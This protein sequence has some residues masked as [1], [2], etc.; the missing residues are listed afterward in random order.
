[1]KNYVLET[2]A[3]RSRCFSNGLANIL[4]LPKGVPS[5]V[6]KML[7]ETP[8]PLPRDHLEEHTRNGPPKHPWNHPGATKEH[9]RKTP[10]QHPRNTQGT[11]QEHPRNTPKA[12]QTQPISTLKTSLEHPRNTQRAPR[13]AQVHPRSTPGSPQGAAQKHSKSVPGASPE[14][15]VTPPRGTN[16]FSLLFNF[17]RTGSCNLTTQTGHFTHVLNHSFYT[18]VKSHAVGCHDTPPVGA[19]CWFYFRNT[20]F[21]NCHATSFYTST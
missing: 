15:G 8:P 9:P 16:V 3:P 21:V 13:N 2:L 5:T 6:S 19:N 1:M 7:S 14:M 12:P 4:A 20:H 17:Y 11:P 18:C 10:K